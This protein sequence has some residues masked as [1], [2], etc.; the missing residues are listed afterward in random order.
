MY[1]DDICIALKD[2][3]E[4]I[5]VRKFISDMFEGIGMKVTKYMSNSS[6]MHVKRR[7]D[8]CHMHVR[9]TTL[10]TYIRHESSASV[11]RAI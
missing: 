9:G 3:T 4:A 2:E 5:E 10:S 6:H 8:G 11:K 1:I 7:S